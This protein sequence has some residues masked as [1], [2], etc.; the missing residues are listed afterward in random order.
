MGIVTLL[1]SAF[2]NSEP[3]LLH[4][5]PNTRATAHVNQFEEPAAMRDDALDNDGYRAYPGAR[6]KGKQEQLNFAAHVL[7][8]DVKVVFQLGSEKLEPAHLQEG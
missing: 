2:V 1:P 6:N 4:F 8:I 3:C 7:V 5:C